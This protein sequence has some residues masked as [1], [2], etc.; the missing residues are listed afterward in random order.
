MIPAKEDSLD[1]LSHLS[2]EEMSSL[3]KYLNN[4]FQFEL[5]YYKAQTTFKHQTVFDPKS[6]K[7]LFIFLFYILPNYLII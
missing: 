7:V 4:I 1:Y 6:R 2:T 5:D 3:T